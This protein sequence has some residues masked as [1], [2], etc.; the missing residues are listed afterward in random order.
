MLV[1]KPNL[2]HPERDIKNHTKNRSTL[3]IR[4]L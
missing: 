2:S 3:R 1:I 4:F